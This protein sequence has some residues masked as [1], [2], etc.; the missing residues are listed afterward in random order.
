[1][2]RLSILKILLQALRLSA[3]F[4]KLYLQ[5]GPLLS[6]VKEKVFHPDKTMAALSLNVLAEVSKVAAL[7]NPLIELS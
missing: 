5:Q 6:L 4:Y 7:S 3:S 1:M 2:T